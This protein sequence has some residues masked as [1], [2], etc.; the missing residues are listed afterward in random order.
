MNHSLCVHLKADT[1]KKN[2]LVLRIFGVLKLPDGIEL[3]FDRNF[4]IM[5]LQLGHKI[6]ISQP[7]YA[8]FENGVVYKYA[9]GSTLTPKD[10][11]NPKVIR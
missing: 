11:E 3:T 1:D 2:A 4:E 7:I 9:T 5:G 8:I 6:G 10:L